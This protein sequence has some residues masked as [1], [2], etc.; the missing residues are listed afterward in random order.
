MVLG[1]SGIHVLAQ[2]LSTVD[3]NQSSCSTVIGSEG[4]R[5][6]GE[7]TNELNMLVHD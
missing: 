4:G 2:V 3:A 5:T 6:F 1:L 7:L